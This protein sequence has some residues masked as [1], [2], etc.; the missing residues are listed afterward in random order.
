M[1]ILDIVKAMLG[2]NQSPKG[3]SGT[4]TIVKMALPMILL[5]LLRNSQSKKK[6]EALGDA[7]QKHTK[8]QLDNDIFN[9]IETADEQDGSKIL[10]HIFGRDKSGIV[11]E[12]AKNANVSTEDAEGVIAKLMPVIMEM[13]ANKTKTDRSPSR[14]QDAVTEELSKVQ[15]EAGLPNI[16]ESIKD[17]LGGGS[18][19][20]SSP[21]G[22]GLG[23]LFKDILTGNQDHEDTD[24]G[25]L[26]DSLGGKGGLGDLL[27]K[28][29]GQ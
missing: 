4:G 19:P 2:G 16:T 15:R 9:K 17:M 25:G 1:D 26:L 11:E 10:G 24:G 20:Q 7:L 21:M 12:I 29:L 22:G 13:L 27:G 18:K 28:M 14:I 3:N 6:A 5:A 8:D 23:D